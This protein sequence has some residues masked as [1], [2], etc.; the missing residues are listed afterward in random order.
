MICQCLVKCL[1]LQYQKHTLVIV[2]YFRWPCNCDSHWP[3]MISDHNCH[4]NGLFGVR[5]IKIQIDVRH[6]YLHVYIYHILK[7]AVKLRL[8][9]KVQNLRLILDRKSSFQV[10]GFATFQAPLALQLPHLS[11]WNFRTS[12]SASA[13][14]PLVLKLPHLS[15]AISAPLACA[16]IC[17]L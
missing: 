15:A 9:N 2:E 8:T 12:C 10:N 16:I 11:L 6:T 14:G 17:G 5:R 1:G 4:F 13:S 3:E 7:R